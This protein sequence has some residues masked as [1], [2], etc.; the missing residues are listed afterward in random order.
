VNRQH[1]A[2]GA[3]HVE[4]ATGLIEVWA[5]AS[6]VSTA[7]VIFTCHK[8]DSI[9]LEVECQELMSFVIDIGDGR[10]PTGATLA[11][12]VVLFGRRARKVLLR[13]AGSGKTETLGNRH[14]SRAVK[15][16]SRQ[17]HRQIFG[18]G[19]EF[20]DILRDNR[21]LQSGKQVLD[22]GCPHTNFHDIAEMQNRLQVPRIMPAEV[23]SLFLFVNQG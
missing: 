3:T 7:R 11:A 13:S 9:G 15:H 18:Q 17:P 22:V 4:L 1:C 21:E 16:Q 14:R 6:F 20:F 8:S 5:A 23:T 2:T 10:I 19:A 12:L